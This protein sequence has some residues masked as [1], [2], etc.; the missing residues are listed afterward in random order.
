PKLREAIAEA[1]VREGMRYDPENEIVVTCGSIEAISATLLALLQP[2]DEVLVPSPS[3]PS[4]VEAIRM[5]GGSP[6]F[7]PLVEEENFALDPTPSSAPSRDG[8]WRCSSATPTILRA[9]SIR[10]RSSSGWSRWPSAT[11]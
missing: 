9:P 8:P 10:A 3:Y 2:G 7:V 1:L 5:A 4:Y 11:T 6:R